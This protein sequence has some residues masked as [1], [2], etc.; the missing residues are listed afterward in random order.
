MTV[1][2]RSKAGEPVAL[3]A[4]DGRQVEKDGV[5]HVEGDLVEETADAYIVG[6]KPPKLPDDPTPE[7][8]A[9]HDRALATHRAYPKSAWTNAGGS[10]NADPDVPAPAGEETP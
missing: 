1:N 4:A 3:G 7:E 10:K 5:I 9:A 2:L 6:A 8:R